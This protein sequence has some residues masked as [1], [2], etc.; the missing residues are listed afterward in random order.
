[1]TDKKLTDDLDLNEKGLLNRAKGAAEEAK[2]RA[3]NAMGGLTG[4]G[5]QQLKGYSDLEW[6]QYLDAAGYPKSSQ[7]PSGYRNPPAAPLKVKALAP[8]ARA[9]AAIVSVILSICPCF[10]SSAIT[11]RVVASGGNARGFGRTGGPP[12]PKLPRLS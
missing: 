8:S 3:R 11:A 12:R 1:M 6:K 2:G 5:G 4:D 9:W 10:M 7:L